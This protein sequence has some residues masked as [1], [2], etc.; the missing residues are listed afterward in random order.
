MQIVLSF[1][2]FHI[3]FSA[4]SLWSCGEFPPAALIAADSLRDI[5][6]STPIPTSNFFPNFPAGFVDMM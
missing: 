4:A 6:C 1:L 2:A 3:A 5:G